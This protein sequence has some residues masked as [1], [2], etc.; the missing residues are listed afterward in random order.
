MEAIRECANILDLTYNDLKYDN[1]RQTLYSNDKCK[2][3]CYRNGYLVS[4]NNINEGYK[5]GNTTGRVCRNGECVVGKDDDNNHHDDMRPILR[6]IT[7][8]VLNG[9]FW[10]N[11]YPNTDTMVCI[12]TPKKRCDRSCPIV[13]NRDQSPNPGRQPHWNYNCTWVRLDY[14]Q[15]SEFVG[16]DDRLRIDIKAND[17]LIIG[18]VINENI[19]KLMNEYIDVKYVVEKA[20]TMTPNEIAKGFGFS[21]TFLIM[22]PS[23]TNPIG[24]IDIEIIFVLLNK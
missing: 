13:I 1:S 10:Y 11:E 23:Q 18:T 6:E 24:N 3:S 9:T 2:L 14:N 19:Y 12:D 7:V 21:H 17:G 8:K 22:D 15:P 20:K 16:N 5:C 4:H